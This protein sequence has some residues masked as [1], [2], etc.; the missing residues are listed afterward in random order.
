MIVSAS[1]GIAGRVMKGLS[2]MHCIILECNAA[3]SQENARA[4]EL[5]L[6]AAILE[7]LTQTTEGLKQ[8]MGSNADL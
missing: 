5:K 4:A 3:Q 8:A 1:S 7:E 6:D 2:P